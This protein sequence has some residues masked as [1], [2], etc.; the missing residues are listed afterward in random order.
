MYGGT[1]EPCGN[2]YFMC[3]GKMGVEENKQH[4]AK[5][6]PLFDKLFGIK[7]DRYSVHYLLLV[8]SF[9]LTINYWT[10]LTFENKGLG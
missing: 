5:L 10:L 6:Y 9:I 8:L 2:A 4:A 1:S 7:N 3:I